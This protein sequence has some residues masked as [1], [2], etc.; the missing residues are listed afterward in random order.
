MKGKYVNHEGCYRSFMFFLHS[1]IQKPIFS[2]RNELKKHMH[3]EYDVWLPFD[4]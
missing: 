4:A 2:K 3:I 1:N